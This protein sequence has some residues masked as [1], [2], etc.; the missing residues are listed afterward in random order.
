[1]LKKALTYNHN[2]KTTKCLMTDLC[3]KTNSKLL[4]LSL[5]LFKSRLN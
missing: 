1:M 4:N 5:T 3:F 2:L